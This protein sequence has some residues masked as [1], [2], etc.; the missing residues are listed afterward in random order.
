MKK[1]KLKSKNKKDKFQKREWR[2]EKDIEKGIQKQFLN[3]KKI[4]K[5]K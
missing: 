5:Y 3:I 2:E 4:L 1:E